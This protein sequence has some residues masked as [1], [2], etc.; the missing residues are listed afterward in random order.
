MKKLSTDI[1]TFF[2]IKFPKLNTIISSSNIPGEGEHKIYQYM[3]DTPD[4][5]KDTNTVIYG[6]DA[7]LIMLSL[8][9]TQNYLHI[10]TNQFLQ[11]YYWH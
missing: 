5:H 1:G 4:Y 2:E 10:T 3:R 11:K 6:L 7:D 8:K 9:H